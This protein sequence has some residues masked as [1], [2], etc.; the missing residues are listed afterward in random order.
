MLTICGQRGCMGMLD[1]TGQCL[2]PQNQRLVRLV[3]TNISLVIEQSL[4]F[5]FNFEI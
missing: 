4:N 1:Q 5:V 2:Q 3:L